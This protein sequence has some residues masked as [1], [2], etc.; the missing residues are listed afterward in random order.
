MTREYEPKK[1]RPIVPPLPDVY[2]TIEEA[3]EISGLSSRQIAR[4]MKSEKIGSVHAGRTTLTTREA[5]LFY[6][7][8]DPSR[9]HDPY[10]KSRARQ[11]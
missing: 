5:V 9:K 6:V 1:S 10:K 8:E 4:A 7:D 3:S 2:I 11:F